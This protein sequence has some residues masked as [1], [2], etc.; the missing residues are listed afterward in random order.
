ME[1]IPYDRFERLRLSQLH[2][3]AAR[4]ATLRNWEF[5]GGV[6]V[7][8]ADGF[9][10]FLCPE[11]SPDTLGSI[12]LDLLDLP[13]ALGARVLAAIE[14]PLQSGMILCTFTAA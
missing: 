5:M 6:W 10:A 7:G 11:A 12:E 1:L 14:L 4:I 3:D 2:P 13:E 9:T 8:E